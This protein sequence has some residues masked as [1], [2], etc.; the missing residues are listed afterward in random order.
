MAIEVEISGNEQLKYKSNIRGYSYS[1][2]S[3]PVIPGDSSGSIGSISFDALDDEQTTQHI[4][5][6][7]VLLTD[8]YHGMTTGIIKSLSSN[9]GVVSL[10]GVSGLGRLNIPRTLVPMQST[11]GDFIAY[12][13]G[14]AGI[15]TGFYVDPSFSSTTVITPGYEGDLWVYIKDFCSARNIEITLLNDTITFRPVRQNVVQPFDIISEGWS[16][17]ESTPAQ[18]VDVNY[19]DYVK[20]NSYLAYPKGGWNKSV[21]VYQVDANQ[22][23]T[24]E[25]PVDGYMT[26]VE[27]PVA[28]WN[29]SKVDTA[30]KYTIAGNDGIGISP[31]QWLDNGGSLVTSLADNGQTIIVTLTGANIPNLAPF[32]VGVSSG[33]S[34]YYSSLRIRGAGVFY[35]KK[36]WRQATGLTTAETSNVVGTTIDNLHISTL[37]QAQA[38]A[39]KA[40]INYA[41]PRQE[42]KFSAPALGDF[43]QTP[44][45]LSLSSFA[46]YDAWLRSGEEFNELDIS[47]DIMS[48][49]DFDESLPTVEIDRVGGQVFGNVAG[50]R[51]KYRD[52][53]YRIR[54]AS[55]TPTTLDVTAEWDNLMSDFN[56]VNADV[57]FE[58]FN[59]TFYELSFNDFAIVPMRRN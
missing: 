45:I 49:T 52:S 53:W 51:T 19:Y 36:T 40:V 21:Q 38:A 44:V 17:S 10:Q 16:I 18:Y 55:I 34:D 43:L 30:S 46:E 42:Y 39:S 59:D 33:P 6:D 27:Q 11:I 3:T 41:L 12:V 54:T 22:T 8:S 13:L 57:T 5:G 37:A 29:I 25:L 24:I 9:D 23:V 26:Y 32:S 47:L 48:F 7:E 58:S 35:D 4:F 2:E 20:S 56:T 31:A 14:E 28:F 50:A 15:L 1:E